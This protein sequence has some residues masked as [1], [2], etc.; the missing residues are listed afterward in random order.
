M[1]NLTV[2]NNYHY[3]VNAGSREIK[4][5]DTFK[6]T[7]NLGNIILTIPGLGSLNL[8]DI[9]EEHIGGPSTKAFGVLLSYQGNECIYRYEGEGDLAIILNNLGQA[10]VEGNGDITLMRFDSFLLSEQAAK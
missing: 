9:G 2:T 4:P 6:V 1:Y 3:T 8:L 7:E 5:G 10:K